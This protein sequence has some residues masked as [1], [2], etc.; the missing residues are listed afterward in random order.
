MWPRPL[1][2]EWRSVPNARRV[3]GWDRELA[4]GAREMQVVPR[5]IITLKMHPRRG[6]KTRKC[7]SLVSSE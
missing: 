2:S 7:S 6:P 3:W 1:G 4:T 5:L